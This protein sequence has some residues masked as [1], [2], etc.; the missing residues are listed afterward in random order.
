MYGRISVPPVATEAAIIA[1][2]SGVIRSSNCPMLDCATRFGS[3]WPALVMSPIWLAATF[4]WR[5][6]APAMDSE[7]SPKPNASACCVIACEPIA[8]PS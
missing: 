4:S 5:S 2:I 3:S 6:P 7:S 8:T 1:P